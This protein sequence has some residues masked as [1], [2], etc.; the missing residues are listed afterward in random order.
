MDSVMDPNAASRRE[1]A[2]CIC[3]AVRV[4]DRELVR[5][6]CDTMGI[7][8]SLIRCLEFRDNRLVMAVLPGLQS[9]LEVGHQVSCHKHHAGNEYMDRI[10]LLGGLEKLQILQSDPDEG[11]A[12][13]AHKMIRDFLQVSRDCHPSVWFHVNGGTRPERDP[14]H[15]PKES[16]DS[17]VKRRHDR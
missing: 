7:I 5:L 1:A 12:V 4:G 6:M 11:I 16:D 10:Q 17:G 9:I 14:H 8:D 2:Y 15:A 3:N 13:T